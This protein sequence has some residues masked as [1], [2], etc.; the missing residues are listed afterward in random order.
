MVCLEYEVA[1]HRRETWLEQNPCLSESVHGYRCLPPPL[2]QNIPWVLADVQLFDSLEE[3]RRDFDHSPRF[4]VQHFSA[5]THRL[6]RGGRQ[7]GGSKISHH[8]ATDSSG[9]ESPIRQPR[10]DAPREAA[11][12]LRAIPTTQAI[13]RGCAPGTG[14][15]LV[16]QEESIQASQASGNGPLAQSGVLRAKTG[17][18]RQ[19]RARARRRGAA[20][21]HTEEDGGEAGAQGRVRLAYQGYWCGTES[22]GSRP[23][24][25]TGS[26]VR[27][28]TP[29]RREHRL[30]AQGTG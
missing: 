25:T 10:Q 9:G 16:T 7:E 8:V 18:P 28:Y 22:Q 26:Q 15:P 11:A 4:P 19:A 20:A 30:F 2:S 1:R 3:H 27:I 29:S 23:R 21:V 24:E 17:R 14:H 6:R 12:V 13:R 5:L